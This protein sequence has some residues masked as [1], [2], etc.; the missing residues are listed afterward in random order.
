[1]TA[2]VKVEERDDDPFRFVDLVKPEENKVPKLGIVGIAITKELA[3]LLPEARKPYG[4]IVAARIGEAEYTG[5][6]GLKVGDIIY[7]VNTTPV[8][9]LSALRMAIDGLK[10]ADPLVLQVEREGNLLYLTLS[11]E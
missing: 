4:V 9:T 7:S 1:M 5:Q 10:V 6:G 11:E 8:S 2:M 3:Q